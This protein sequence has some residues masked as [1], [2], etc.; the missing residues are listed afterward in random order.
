[1][2]L[3]SA[4][5][6]LLVQAAWINNPQ[7][8]VILT[9]LRGLEATVHG[10]ATNPTVYIMQSLAEIPR[11]VYRA[12]VE[13]HKET[14][15]KS[16]TLNANP[17]LLDKLQYI[18]ADFLQVQPTILAPSTSFISM[19]LDSIKSVGLSKVITMCGHPVSST[20]VLRNASL[21]QLVS[22]ILSQSSNSDAEKDSGAARKSVVVVDKS[23]TA[24]ILGHNIKLEDDDD[25][26]LFPTTALQSGMLSQ[27]GHN[28]V[29]STTAKL[30]NFH[31][32]TDRQLTRKVISTLL[33]AADERKFRC[34][35][36]ACCLEYSRQELFN[37]A[38]FLPLLDRIRGLDPSNPQSRNIRLGRESCQVYRR[39]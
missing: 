25:V 5:D 16:E 24:E 11:A 38:D 22:Y 18:I 29:P 30:M 26:E 28:F 15:V 13:P 32:P 3:N 31:K 36:V 9:C 33:S 35:A 20:H 12:K 2:V 23:I 17:E 14:L 8:E 27:V 4:N 1:M 10:L 19:G 6:S 21:Q 34:G 39:V 7:D 37:I